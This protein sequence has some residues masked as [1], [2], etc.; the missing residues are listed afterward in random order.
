MIGFG[1]S[2][3][4][5]ADLRVGNAARIPYPDDSVD[6]ALQFTMISSILD[7]GMRAKVAREMSRV[8]RPSGMIVSYDFWI[9]PVNRDV[10][11]LTRRELRALFPGH[12]IEA[13]SVT[14][15]P[16]LARVVASRSYRLAAALQALPPL[17]THILAFI[18]PPPATSAGGVAQ[19][20]NRAGIDDASI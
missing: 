19:R 8:V 7:A 4:P 15:A 14:L 18:T 5:S 3:L 1:Q 2:R 13:R 20:G 16:P 9:N 10:R 6:V 12:R 17:R 11:G